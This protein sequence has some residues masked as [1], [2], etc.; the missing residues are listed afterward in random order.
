[1]LSEPPSPKGVEAVEIPL[2]ELSLRRIKRANAR[3]DTAPTDDLGRSKKIEIAGE[4]NLDDRKIPTA[5]WDE[6]QGRL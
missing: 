3:P 1:M 5:L 2:E 6:W 4:E